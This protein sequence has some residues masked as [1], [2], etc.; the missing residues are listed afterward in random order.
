MTDP[1]FTAQAD[2]AEGPD[3]VIIGAHNMYVGGNFSKVS[4]TPAAT[5][6]FQVSQPGLAIYPAA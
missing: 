4:S 2:T 5:G 3:F 1:S 6:G